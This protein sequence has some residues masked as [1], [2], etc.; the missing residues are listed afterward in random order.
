MT[1]AID[2]AVPAPAEAHY[3]LPRPRSPAL[4]TL[5]ALAAGAALAAAFAPLSLLPLALLCP[6][7]LFWLWQDATPGEVARLGFCFSS[8]TFAVGTYWLYVSIHIFG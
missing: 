4:R 2:S 5:L 6:A 8:A 1:T 7:V 3:R